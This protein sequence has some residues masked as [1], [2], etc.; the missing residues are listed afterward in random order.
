MCV[1]R[2]VRACVCVCA[3]VRARARSRACA[4]VCVHAQALNDDGTFGFGDLSI[5]LRCLMGSSPACEL[6]CAVS[7]VCVHAHLTVQCA[8][9]Q[10]RAR[11]RPCPSLRALARACACASTQPCAALS[12]SACSRKCCESA[13]A[14]AY[15]YAS[16]FARH[17]KKAAVRGVLCCDL[18]PSAAIC[19]DVLCHAVIYKSE[20]CGKKH[21]TVFIVRQYR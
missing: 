14:C 9:P 17:D 4:C 8:R 7:A 21:I 1:D 2:G 10:V 6:V 12:M 16:I 15:T 3:C 20:H 18:Q 13:A 5:C 11:V 19:S